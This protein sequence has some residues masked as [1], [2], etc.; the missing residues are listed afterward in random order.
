MPNQTLDPSRANESLTPAARFAEAR[1]IK[2]LWLP[3]QGGHQD[4]PGTFKVCH[5]VAKGGGKGTSPRTPNLLWNLAGAQK[6]LTRPLRSQSPKRVGSGPLGPPISLGFGGASGLVSAFG[7]G[8][9][10]TGALFAV[11]VMTIVM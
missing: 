1:E 7:P 4:V 9:G 3:G 11:S 8:G 6:S 10:G 2:G 5:R